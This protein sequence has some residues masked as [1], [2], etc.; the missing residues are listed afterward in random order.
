M[1]VLTEPNSLGDALKWE[2]SNDYSREKVTVLAGQVLAA[3]SVVGKVTRVTP[4]TGAADAGNTGTGTCGSVTAGQKTKVGTYLLTCIAAASNAGTFSVRDPDGNLLPDATVGVAYTN[5]QIN[6]ALADAGAED[7]I[8]GDKF[9]IVVSA[10]SGKV[11]AFAEAAVNGSE[12]PVGFLIA[13]V[14]ATSADKQGVI[15]A[16]DALVAMNNLVWPAEISAG[17]KAAAIAALEALGIK[18][19]SLA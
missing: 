6:F 8:V 13:A 17:D 15:I 16:R 1:T 10:G 9:T 3:L 19:V 18:A 2:Q 4:A 12:D 7:F 5:P 14:D 11:V